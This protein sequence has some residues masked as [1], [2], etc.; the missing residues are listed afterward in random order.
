M[1][2]GLTLVLVLLVAATVAAQAPTGTIRGLVEDSTNAMVPGA[3]VELQNL[4]TGE[5]RQAIT[6]R[7]GHYDFVF[8]PVGRYRVTATLAGFKTTAQDTVLEVGQVNQINLRLEVGGSE[9]SITVE[10]TAP[11]VQTASSNAGKVID[12]RRMVDIP[13]NS[14][15][16]QQLTLLVPGTVMPPGGIASTST[17]NVAGQ[18]SDASDYLVDGAPNND[19]RNN[20]VVMVPNIDT[21]QEF[22]FQTNAF[23][24][25]YGRASGG[26]VNIVT[27]SG[28]NEYRGTLFEFLRNDMFDARNY[29][30]DP[31]ATIP[32]FKR[33]VFGAVLGGPV[34]RD[35][36][37]FFASYE[38]RRQRESITL[39]ATVP[40][41]EQRQGIFRDAQGTVV[42]DVSNRLSSAAQ[43]VLGLVPAPNFPGALNSGGPVVKPRNADQ[44]TGKLDHNFNNANRLS[45][46]YLYQRDIRDEP[47]TNT[48]LP[49]FG[50]WRQGLRHHAT[51]THTSIITPRLVN[52]AVL[53]FNLLDGRIYPRELSNP[54]EFG[55]S[56]GINDKIGLPSIN[57]VGW[58]Q[59]G[60]GQAPTG[61]R[62][63]K[64]TF[65]DVASY[66]IGRH[67]LKAG[68]EIRTWRN[69]MYAIDQGTMLFDGSVTGNAMADFLIGQTATVT[70]VFGDQT[71]HLATDVYSLF[72]QDDFRVSDR[73]TLNLGLRWEYFTVPKETGGRKFGVFDVSTGQLQHQDTPFAASKRNLGPRIGFAYD[74]LGKGKTAIRAA[75][76]IFYDQGTVGT[77]R[78]LV[79]NPPEASSI[80]FR[81]TT[82]ADPF[83]GQ[84]AARV[85]SLISIA[86]T[87]PTPYVHS[88]N[89]NVQIEVA[90]NLALDAG[91]Y[92]STGRNQ[93]IALE[94][95]QAAYIPGSSTTT[96]TDSRR[97]FQGFGSIRVQSPVASSKYDSLQVGLARRVA[98]GFSAWGS[99][100]LSRCMDYGSSASSRPQDGRELAGGTRAMRLR[101]ATPRRYQLP[102]GCARNLSLARVE[103][104]PVGVAAHR[105]RAVPERQPAE[106]R[107][108]ERQHPHGESSRPPESR[109]RL[110]ALEP[111][112]RSVGQP[113]RLR[114]ARARAVRKPPTQQRHRSRVQQRRHRVDEGLQAGLESAT[115]VP[116]RG[117]RHHQHRQLRLPGDGTRRH[118]FR[119]GLGHAD[120]SR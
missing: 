5:R 40:T 36:T 26:V 120:H 117:V 79:L 91:Y 38:G 46:S 119:T 104:A 34:I 60:R 100:V 18:R 71:T 2:L 32:P 37:F 114:G 63:P 74:P 94:I 13:L 99:Y 106:C 93:E 52:Q 33:S 57:V 89:I 9:Q 29:F 73:L 77:S 30:D 48:N 14:R 62:D 25:E 116:L 101:R 22:S 23:S 41:A 47:S 1:K 28:G 111:D 12:S 16:I 53:A 87:W 17:G 76:G 98:K 95:N 85:P 8:L 3:G 27:R 108:V 6:D 51:L 54:A 109:R 4:N 110:A 90:R 11:L 65:R 49:G 96:N 20:Q 78:D 86:P 81:G 118:Q 55:I 68:G 66:L 64:F 82:I 102:V 19:V 103:L 35:R 80:T 15:D 107:A 83:A 105:R 69:R 44:F 10:G 70:A 113:G 92:G 45:L 115:A 72:F 42:L 24:A 61:W 97:P 39:R 50:D 67:S 84:G 7:Q 112:P 31:K 21:I 56:N 75:Y 59:L 43:K 88:Y 58:F